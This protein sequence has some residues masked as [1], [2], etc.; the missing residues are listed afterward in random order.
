MSKANPTVPIR[1]RKSKM[2]STAPILFQYLS[3]SFL[4]ILIMLDITPNKELNSVAKI[5]GFG[6]T[7]KPSFALIVV[8]TEFSKRA[9]KIKVTP[10]NVIDNFEN[11]FLDTGDFLSPFSIR[12]SSLSCRVCSNRMAA[13][14]QGFVSGVELVFRPPT[15]AARLLIKI[16]IKN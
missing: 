9:N 15:A 2:L 13:N 3:L 6:I 11:K 4:T 1:K 5:K 16:N 8:G 7:G 14:G 12:D 10:E